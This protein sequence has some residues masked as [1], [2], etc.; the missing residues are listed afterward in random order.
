MLTAPRSIA[1]RTPNRTMAP[2]RNGCSVEMRALCPRLSVCGAATQANTTSSRKSA[3]RL[4]TPCISPSRAARPPSVRTAARNTLID[5][6]RLS[7]LLPAAPDA[8]QKVD[9]SR[10]RVQEATLAPPD[11]A[12]RSDHAVVHDRRG[13]GLA[14]APDAAVGRG[15]EAGDG[16]HVNADAPCLRRAAAGSP[17]AAHGKLGAPEEPGILDVDVA[18][19]SQHRQG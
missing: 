11:E 5:A 18:V 6:L 17:D 16:R 2:R 7:P 9:R 12:A 19:R 10:A 1:S 8:A 13:R 15:D 4:N 3:L 14:A